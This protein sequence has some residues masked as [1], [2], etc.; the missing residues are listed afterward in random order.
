MGQINQSLREVF[1][2]KRNEAASEFARKH[3]RSKK[4]LDQ[5]ELSFKRFREHSARVLAGASITSALLF[6]GMNLP[7]FLAQ[8]VSV[9]KH[10]YA[11]SDLQ[12]LIKNLP[13]KIPLPLVKEKSIIDAVEELYG[14]HVSFELDN[15]R[16][17][18]YHGGMGLEQHL[19]RYEG[20]NLGLHAYPD[21]GFA[22]ALGSFGHFKRKDVPDAQWIEEEKYYVVLQ[23]FLI[24]TWNQD[25]Q[26][27]KPWYAFRKFVVFNPANG[28]AVVAALGDS[29]PAVWTGKVFGGSPEVME[30]LGFYPKYTRGD[31]V[32]LF[33]DD[34]KNEVP[35][36]PIEMKKL[37]NYKKEAV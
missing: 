4:Y 5:K 7:Q 32:I 34:P 9:E 25:W 12:G 20:D 17:P 28:K 26:K 21:E 23:T 19:R 22:P 10:A 36:G 18:F 2:Y 6:G 14:I 29:G 16:L 33:L 30:G 3:P 15:N 37:D 24:P 11:P 31:V 27:L 1:L 8:G 35:L 13:Q